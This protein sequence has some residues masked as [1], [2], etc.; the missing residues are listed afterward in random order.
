M[1]EVV[2]VDDGVVF[3]VGWRYDFSIQ[4]YN[5]EID[6]V[7]MKPDLMLSCSPWQLAEVNIRPWALS[8][9]TQ[10]SG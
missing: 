3:E 4:V 5:A 8:H 9:V 1:A 10:T 7:N 6:Q 2:V